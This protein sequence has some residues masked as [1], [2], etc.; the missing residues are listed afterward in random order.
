MIGKCS[1]P[2]LRLDNPSD[3]SEKHPRIAVNRTKTLAQP[4]PI[5]AILNFEIM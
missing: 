3:S 4:S 2:T 5:L 1:T